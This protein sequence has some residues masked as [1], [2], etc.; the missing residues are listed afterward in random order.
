[1]TMGAA[2]KGSNATTDVDPKLLHLVRKYSNMSENAED[3]VNHL[4][5]QHREYQRKDLQRLTTQ[6]ESALLAIES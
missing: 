1:M 2:K 3:V 4:R 6:V 5:S